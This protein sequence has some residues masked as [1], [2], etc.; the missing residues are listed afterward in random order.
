[1]KEIVGKYGTGANGFALNAK[2]QFGAMYSVELDLTDATTAKKKLIPQVEKLQKDKKL[3]PSNK[4]DLLL[5]NAGFAA[6]VT[7][8]TKQDLPPFVGAMHA[9]H[10]AAYEKLVESKLV[11]ESQV[12]V[13]LTA[14]A[15]AQMCAYERFT[16]YGKSL[17]ESQGKNTKAPD[18]RKW[19]QVKK[20]PKNNYNGWNSRCWNE[21]LFLDDIKKAGKLDAKSAKSIFKQHADAFTFPYAQ[22]KS[23]NILM[24]QAY[25][26]VRC[27]SGGG[28]S[29][30]YRGFSQGGLSSPWMSK[31]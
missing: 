3:G 10:L 12:K 26:L 19:D 8:N 22:A 5:L 21:S 2:Q 6:G 13:V 14:S 9:G 28:R 23:S 25:V 4:V 1:M 15:A 27:M 31:C 11:D 29:V 7:D 17:A 30:R 16:L 18:V 20:A 24:A